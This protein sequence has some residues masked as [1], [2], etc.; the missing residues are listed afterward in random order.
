MFFAV[1]WKGMAWGITR[2]HGKHQW[3]MHYGFVRGFHMN[4]FFW[5]TSLITYDLWRAFVRI[6]V[7]QPVPKETNKGL[8][9]ADVI[10]GQCAAHRTHHWGPSWS[11]FFFENIKC[12]TFFFWICVYPTFQIQ[13]W[14]CGVWTLNFGFWIVLVPHLCVAAPNAAIWILDFA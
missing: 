14:R 5:E 4:S 1:L 7:D 12:F 6:R 3:S 9:N 11:T 8:F 10:Q 13:T 2:K